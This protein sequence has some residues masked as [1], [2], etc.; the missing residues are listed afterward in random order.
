V[1]HVAAATNVRLLTPL[2]R[3]HHG[4]HTR[5]TA[6][7]FELLQQVQTGPARRL[8]IPQVHTPTGNRTKRCRRYD[9]IPFLMTEQ[10]ALVRGSGDS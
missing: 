5:F 4:H 2:F 10:G 6:P 3:E 8:L 1:S 9:K 7:R